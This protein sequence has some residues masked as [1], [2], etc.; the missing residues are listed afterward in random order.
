M[1]P[2]VIYGLVLELF[3]CQ[4]SSDVPF[5]RLLSSSPFVMWF[6][7]VLASYIVGFLPGSDSPSGKVTLTC[8]EIPKFPKGGF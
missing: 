2:N 1:K 5:I 3:S 7:L 4:E 6:L 8:Q